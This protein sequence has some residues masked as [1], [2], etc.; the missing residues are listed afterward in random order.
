MSESLERVAIW[1]YVLFALAALPALVP[2]AALAVERGPGRKRFIGALAVLGVAIG[3][4]LGVSIFRG[5]V[6]AMIENHYIAYHV[7][8]LSRGGQITALYVVVACG[9]LIASSY[10]DLSVLGVLNLVAVPVLMWMTVSGFISLWCFWAAI[11]SVI[12]DVHLRKR[13]RRQR[14]ASPSARVGDVSNVT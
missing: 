10:R 2:V 11:V 1:V 8:A 12:I 9:A 4:S 3:V 7:S 13:A 14:F 5:S 6:N